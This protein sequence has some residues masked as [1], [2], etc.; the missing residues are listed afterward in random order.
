M[1]MEEFEVIKSNLSQEF[2]VEEKSV[3]IEI[4]GDG[5]GKWILELVDEHGNSTVWDDLFETD[6]SALSEA[7]KAILEEGI[8]TFIGAEDSKSGIN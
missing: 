2:S 4:L 8:E 1:P 3:S 7:K 5:N 6:K